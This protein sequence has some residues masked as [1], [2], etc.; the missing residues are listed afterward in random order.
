MDQ[1]GPS[2]HIVWRVRV[3]HSHLQII[4]EEPVHEKARKVLERELEEKE[5]LSTL[6]GSEILELK[7][8]VLSV[9]GPCTRTCSRDTGPNNGSDAV[10]TRSSSHLDPVPLFCRCNWT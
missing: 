3:S 7:D 2:I 8:Q 6:Q 5:K 4:Q 1:V 10:L 9:P